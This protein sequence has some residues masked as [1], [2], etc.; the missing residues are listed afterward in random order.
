MDTLLPVCAAHKSLPSWKC[1]WS[2]TVH[3]PERA[4][5]S[6]GW[7]A[8]LRPHFCKLNG[9]VARHELSVMEHEL[10]HHQL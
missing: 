2:I 5:D 8:P 4:P 3:H 9:S 10:L 6:L 7:A 1:R